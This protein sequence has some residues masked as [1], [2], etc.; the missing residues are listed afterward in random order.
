MPKTG[1]AKSRALT[2]Y[3]LKQG[4]TAET[5]IKEAG[6]LEKFTVGD[7]GTVGDLYLSVASPRPPQWA[8]LFSGTTQ[9][10]LPQLSGTQSSA[11][12]VVKRKSR[13]FAVTFGYGRH[14]LLPGAFE[15]NFGLIVTLNSIPTDQVRS[16]DVKS[17]DAIFRH[18]RTQASR[19]GS[20]RDFGMDIEQDLLRAVTGTPADTTLGGRLT[21]MDALQVV[22]PTTVQDLPNL[23]ERYCAT[24]PELSAVSAAKSA[25][26]RSAWNRSLGAECSCRIARWRRGLSRQCPLHLGRDASCGQVTGSRRT[27]AGGFVSAANLTT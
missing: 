10:I 3:L 12:L 26:R 23:L 4:Q 13:L 2:I 6:G 19:E 18:T 20:L 14:L 15:E 17:F 11:V 21:G 27:F 9:P 25:S 24:A 22:V 8:S 7:G 1:K 16:M 5:A